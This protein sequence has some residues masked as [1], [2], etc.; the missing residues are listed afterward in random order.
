[1][2]G[3]LRP[4][5]MDWIKPKYDQVYSP[6]WL[7]GILVRLNQL[8]KGKSLQK[9]AEETGF[10]S[11]SLRRHMRMGPPPA[12]LIRAMCE[13]HKVSADW[14]LMGKGKPRR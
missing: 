11:E 5:T 12:E 8:A 4:D 9:L 7:L 3:H 10:Q 14:L 2:P 13:I 6:E 1:M